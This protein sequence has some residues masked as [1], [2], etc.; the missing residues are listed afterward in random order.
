MGPENDELMNGGAPPY[1]RVTVNMGDEGDDDFSPKYDEYEGSTDDGMEEDYDNPLEGEYDAGCGNYWRCY[2][3]GHFWGNSQSS[4]ARDFYRRQN[5]TPIYHNVPSRMRRRICLIC[6]GVEVAIEFAAI[7]EPN[8][9]C[10][11]HRLVGECMIAGKK[12]L[13]LHARYF[14]DPYDM[15][16][17]WGPEFLWDCPDTSRESWTSTWTCPNLS[18]R[19]GA[20][21]S[22]VFAM[23]PG[24][25]VTTLEKRHL[26]FAMGRMF[27]HHTSKCRSFHMQ[28]LCAWS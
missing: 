1:M 3:C 5:D 22:Y 18:Y 9:S 4:I 23:N 14:S 26:F 24:G 20:R 21:I 15:S 10:T 11:W 19:K 7:H 6:E 27:W 8:Y 17:P 2:H 16:G 12:W 13:Y 28:N 25:K